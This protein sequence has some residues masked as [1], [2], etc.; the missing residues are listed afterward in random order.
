MYG[1]HLPW[2]S[3]GLPQ[4]PK[5]LVHREAQG[6]ARMRGHKDFSWKGEERLPSERRHRGEDLAPEQ[7]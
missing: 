4:T 3:E 2:G 6:A 7:E 1:P 5:P